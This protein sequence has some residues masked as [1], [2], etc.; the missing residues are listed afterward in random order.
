MLRRQAKVKKGLGRMIMVVRM[1]M[2][3]EP[4]DFQQ[5]RKGGNEAGPSHGGQQEELK[6]HGMSCWRKTK[7]SGKLGEKKV[8]RK[9]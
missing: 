7:M 3:M 6:Q 4:Q 2:E 8:Q 1:V 9:A 5:H